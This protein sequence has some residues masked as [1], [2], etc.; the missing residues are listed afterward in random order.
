MLTEIANGRFGPFV[1]S[2]AEVGR[3]MLQHI[4]RPQWAHRRHQLVG[5]W[6]RGRAGTCGHNI[7]TSVHTLAMTAAG[8]LIAVLI[9]LWLGL[10]FLAKTWLNLELVWAMSL[11][12]IGALGVCS[13]SFGHQKMARG[14]QFG[15]DPRKSSSCMRPSKRAPPLP[16][17]R[18]DYSGFVLC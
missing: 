10:R 3:N 9:Y 14:Q 6:P 8:G 16:R 5:Y 15:F 4:R 1:T 17:N 7:I 12:P 18:R 2:I 11:V 13:A